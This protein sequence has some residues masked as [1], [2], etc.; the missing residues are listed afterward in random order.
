MRAGRSLSET[1]MQTDAYSGVPTDF[2]QYLQKFGAQIEQSTADKI[3]DKEVGWTF[4]DLEE[5]AVYDMR[6]TQN[7][8]FWKGVLRKKRITNSRSTKT[9]DIY[10]TQGIW[11][12]AGKELALGR[13]T[14]SLTAKDLVKLMK[15]AFSGNESGDK[16]LIIYGSDFLE[17][18]ENVEFTKNVTVGAK[19]QVYGLEFNSIISK[20]GTLL[21]VHDKTLDDMGMADKAFILD[22]NFLRK[23]TQGFK[24]HNIDFKSNAEK[25]VDGRSLIEVCGLVL[26][27]PN[28]HSRV[29]LGAF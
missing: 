10:F 13:T 11:N 3:A 18:V 20:F 16:K 12:Q 8:S 22:A 15:H 26:K 4:N 21:G 25:D 5:E 17:A 14:T 1:Q 7:I 19:S 29:A 2:T 6:R 27:N 24:T 9:E 28:A 23:W